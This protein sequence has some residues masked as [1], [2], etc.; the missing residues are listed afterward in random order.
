V[1]SHIRVHG[2]A[3]NYV[4]LFLFAILSGI[5]VNGPGEA[6]LITA[7]VYV[8]NHHLPLEP[9]ILIAA[10]GG[11]LGGLGGFIIGKHGGRSILIAPGPLVRFRRRMLEHSEEMYLRWDSLA[12]L[13][14]PAWAAGIHDIR[15]WKFLWLNLASALIWAGL[16][17][18][19]AYFLGSRITTEFS[20]EIGWVI[21]GVVA[22]LVVYYITQRVLRAPS[23]RS[24]EQ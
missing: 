14:T 2:P 15:W 4:G 22:V 8:S 17:G 19:G 24:R 12:V 18:V 5:G 6:A 11:F 10:A 9:V 21:G 23:H 13:M 3:I 16:I 20:N 1:L 7:A